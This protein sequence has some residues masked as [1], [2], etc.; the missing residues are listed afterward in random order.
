MY[1]HSDNVTGSAIHNS[2]CTH[3][4]TDIVTEFHTQRHTQTHTHVHKFVLVSLFPI[5][6]YKTVT[7]KG[8][9]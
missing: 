3:V 2:K 9:I 4:Y 7:E 8:A 5:H 1:A 6:N